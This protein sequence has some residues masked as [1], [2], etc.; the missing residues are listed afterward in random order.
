MIPAALTL[1]VAELAV[2][3]V[4]A[5]MLFAATPSPIPGL[6]DADGDADAEG[7]TGTPARATDSTAGRESFCSDAGV[8][9]RTSALAEACG[10]CGACVADVG[11]E[12]VKSDGKESTRPPLPARADEL[13][14]ARLVVDGVGDG[15]LS[16]AATPSSDCRD[17][18]LAW[19][20]DSPAAEET[21]A[22]DF[23]IEEAGSEDAPSC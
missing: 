3:G 22:I 7:P 17:W 20:S 4:V 15:A 6:G 5:G 14:G 19:L 23:D 8:S 13:E 11:V 1:T 12:E 18:P 2:D 10:A 16:E 9:D 21:P